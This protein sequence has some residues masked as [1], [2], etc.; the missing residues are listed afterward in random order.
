MDDAVLIP[1]AAA[2]VVFPLLARRRRALR[3]QRLNEDLP[4]LIEGL[5]LALRAGHS[6]ESGFRQAGENRSGP[7][8]EV[9]E[10]VNLLMLLQIR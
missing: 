3:C 4:A 8:N 7:L 10:G 9:V 6:L 1:V 5:A 2:L